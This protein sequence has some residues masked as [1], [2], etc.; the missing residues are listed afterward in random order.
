MNPLDRREFIARAAAGA[1]ALAAT[2]IPA[3][4]DARAG[5][6]A[7]EG[8]AGA[9]RSSFPGLADPVFRP[10]TLGA[11]QPRFAL[12]YALFDSLLGDEA[13]IGLAIRR[14]MEMS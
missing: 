14:Q 1:S 7:G 6:G 2:G 12:S 3:A 8:P 10:L 9:R 4:A 5:T 13:A 11:I